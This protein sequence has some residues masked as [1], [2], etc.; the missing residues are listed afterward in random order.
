[1]GEP[2]IQPLTDGVAPGEHGLALL[3]AALEGDE[4]VGNRLASVTI[5]VLTTAVIERY[6]SYPAAVLALVDAPLVVRPSPR[7]HRTLLTS[8]SSS[9]PSSCASVPGTCPYPRQARR[10]SR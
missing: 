8:S 7:P 3:Q 2:V 6:L 5:D 4:L 10:R 9:R 1:R